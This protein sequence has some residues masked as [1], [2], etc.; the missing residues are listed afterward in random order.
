[1]TKISITN[2]CKAM[3]EYIDLHKN[4]MVATLEKLVTME[5]GTKDDEDVNTLGNYLCKLF[6]NEGFE[7]ELIDVGSGGKTLVGMLGKE[8]GGKPIIFTGHMDT[9][10]GKGTINENP[11][12]IENG[13]AYGPGVLDMKSGIVISYYVI[14]ALNAVGFDNKPIK[15]LFSGNEEC[16]HENSTGIDVMYNEGKDGLCAFN[17]ETG[18]IGKE[19]C[20]GRKGAITFKLVVHGKSAHSGAAFLDGINA[21]IEASHKII[22]LSNLTNLEEGYTLS[23]DVVHGGTRSNIVAEKCEIECDCRVK[24]LEQLDMLTVKI[25]EIASNSVIEGTTCEVIIASKMFPFEINSKTDALYEFVAGISEDI[26]QG[27]P[28]SM[29]VGGASDASNLQRGGTPVICSM[30]VIGEHNHTFDEYAI[31]ETLFDRAKLLTAVVD[32]ID[33]FKIKGGE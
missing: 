23:P 30:G 27:R 17:M 24:T 16:L 25:Y 33:E 2:R 29:Y 11:F 10:F 28:N 15:I 13:K 22:K 1:M 3:H 7:C 9:V 19:I 32:R 8:R 26:G 4:D 14:K 6:T 31:V 12:R 20:T 5:S 21:V 18:L